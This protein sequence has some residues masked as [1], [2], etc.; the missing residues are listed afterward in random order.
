[1]G[2]IFVTFGSC[3]KVLPWALFGGSRP[4][5][6]NLRASIMV[7]IEGTEM[8]RE[9]WRRMSPMPVDPPRRKRSR[10]H[11]LRG[12]GVSPFSLHHYAPR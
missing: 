4:V 5:V 3:T 2:G 10:V 12:A 9:G 1:M 7:Y 11:P 6:A 8:V